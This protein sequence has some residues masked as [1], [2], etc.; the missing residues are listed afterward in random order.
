[1]NFFVLVVTW[2]LL[3]DRI[4]VQV[5]PHTHQVKLCDFGSAKVLVG[6]SFCV[7]SLDIAKVLLEVNLLSCLYFSFLH[8]AYKTG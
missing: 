1:M 2:K 5:N 6:L 3:A 8:D 4:V 7:L